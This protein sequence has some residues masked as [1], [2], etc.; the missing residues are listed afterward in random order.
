MRRQRLLLQRVALRDQLVELFL[1]CGD[2][3]G[4]AF[5]VGGAGEGGGLFG[6][7]AQVVADDGDAVVEIG[8]RESAVVGHGVLDCAAGELLQPRLQRA[9][10][11][12]GL[13]GALAPVGGLSL[14]LN[15]GAL[16]IVGAQAARRVFQHRRRRAEIRGAPGDLRRRGGGG[17]V[18][19]ERQG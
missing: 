9:Q 6:Q 5:L 19:E 17:L 3:L 12:F 11:R 8:A 10:A 13:E 2:A 4:G 1:L 16:A 15:G 14:R 18:C 7:L